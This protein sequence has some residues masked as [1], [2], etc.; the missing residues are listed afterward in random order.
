MFDGQYCGPMKS[1]VSAE[2]S[3]LQ[4]SRGHGGPRGVILL[5]CEEVS[6]HRTNGWQKLL[7]KQHVSVIRTIYLDAGID[8]NQVST[9]K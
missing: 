6:G 9:S 1:G 3:A 4:L 2:S 7:S 8:E 5:K